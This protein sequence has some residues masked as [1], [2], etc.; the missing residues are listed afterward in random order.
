MAESG[1]DSGLAKMVSDEPTP[2]RRLAM[3]LYITN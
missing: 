3:L 1:Q 2:V